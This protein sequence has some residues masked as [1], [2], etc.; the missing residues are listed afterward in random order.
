MRNDY[1]TNRIWV[2]EMT[3]QDGVFRPIEGFTTK[4]GAELWLVHHRKWRASVSNRRW[5]QKLRIAKYVPA[6]DTD[7]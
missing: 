7:D 2:I 6:V 4:S 3:N 1:M 5:A